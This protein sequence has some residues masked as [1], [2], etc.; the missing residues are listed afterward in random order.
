MFLA[1]RSK[2]LSELEIRKKTLLPPRP[3][4]WTGS[5]IDVVSIHQCLL[6]TGGKLIHHLTCLRDHHQFQCNKTITS[7]T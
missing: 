5:Q 6:V 4:T 7:N 3:I 2:S 1:E